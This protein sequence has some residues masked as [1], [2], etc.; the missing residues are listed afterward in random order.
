MS[1]LFRLPASI[2]HDPA[3]QAWLHEQPGELGELARRWFG[4]LRACGPD[5]FETI[6]DGQATACV[7]DA[8]F[9]YVDVFTAHINVGFFRGVDL[10]D[11][12]GLLEGAGK[13][14]RHVKLR[15]GQA[16]D[17]AALTAL[18]RAAYADMRTRVAAT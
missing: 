10:P 18:V 4:V 12:S 15:P 6:H 13:V 2:E 14:M 1:A 9:A 7:G 11:P 5:V 3:T 16:I 17:A 8:A